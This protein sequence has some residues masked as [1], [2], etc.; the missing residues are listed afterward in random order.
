[1]STSEERDPLARI[2]AVAVVL[3]TLATAFVGYRAASASRADDRAAA[4]AQRLSVEAMERTVRGQQRGQ[5]EF[6]T[7]TLLERQ[8]RRAANATR[9]ALLG[10]PAVQRAAALERAR[11]DRVVD[12]T[13]E[14]TTITEEGPEGPTADPRFPNKLLVRHDRDADVAAALQDAADEESVAWDGMGTTYASILTMLAVSLF[15]L[16]FTLSVPGGARLVFVGVGILLGLVGTFRAV[17]LETSRPERAPRAAA[18]AFADA[19]VVLSTQRTPEE[20]R[21][22]VRGYSEA[23]RLRPSFSLAYQ[24]RATAEFIAGAPET[25]SS[26]IATTSDESLERSVA[27]LRKARGLG[28]ET[29]SVLTSL[30]ANEF[31]RGLRRNDDG[32]LAD[33]AQYARDALSLDPGAPVIRSNLAVALLA[34]GRVQE[35][36]EALRSYLR[37]VLFHN[38][39]GQRRRSDHLV[40]EIVAGTLS[41]L[42]ILRIA[43]PQLSGEILAAK[44]LVVGSATLGRV[45]VGEWSGSVG[46]PVADVL[47]NALQVRRLRLDGFD[48]ERDVLSIQW[49]RRPQ[50][51]DA[52]LAEARMSGKVLAAPDGWAPGEL[53]FG[54]EE[55]YFILKNYR[56]LVDECLPPGDFRVEVYVN[57]QLVE[58]SESSG[59]FEHLDEL[60]L[61]SV[62]MKACRPGAWRVDRRRRLPGVLE[63]ASSA[64][65]SRGIYVVRIADAERMF[66]VDPASRAPQVLERVLDR[67]SQ[68]APGKLR[69]DRPHDDFFARLNSAVRRW[70]RYPGGRALV[71]AGVDDNG[72][73]VVG[74]VYGPD[75]YW[76]DL[77]PFTISDSF[78]IAG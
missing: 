6:E 4:D 78:T 26:L 55:L 64:D 68:V 61:A 62:D 57:G 45:G 30:G 22:A 27:D 8:R 66:G 43:R 11:W 5:A 36:R 20:A 7:F 74:L 23:I 21:E 76:D 67:F 17:M 39:D 75:V 31:L 70:Y 60:F 1:M 12:R 40:Q 54:G 56:Q 37:Y 25:S 18:E 69:F 10:P 24:R 34:L 15:L 49:Y 33:A 14:L 73:F 59:D 2:V 71:G 53:E 19:E 46:K 28:L 41:D 44:E 72:D 32:L 63:G 38:G 29:S 77:E 3:A 52:W 47:S 58:T 13:Q 48:F 16:G 9:E 65:R 50:R 42:E 51:D 35:A